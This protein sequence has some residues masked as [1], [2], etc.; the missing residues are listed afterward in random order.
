MHGQTHE[1]VDDDEIGDAVGELVDAVE[2][3]DEGDAEALGAHHA[4]RAGQ[5]ADLKRYVSN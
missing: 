5:G 3:V 2:G 1:Q 4:Q